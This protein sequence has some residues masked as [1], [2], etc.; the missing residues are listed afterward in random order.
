M[1]L[2]AEV[3]EID[4]ELGSWWEAFSLGSEDEREALMEAAKQ[5]D[6]KRRSHAPVKTRV[7]A[8][9]SA[10][11][12]GDGDGDGDEAAPSEN[13]GAGLGAEPVRKR[14]RRRRKPSEARAGGEPV[15]AAG[16]HSD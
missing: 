2:R 10:D 15:D 12:D 7:A 11:A 16:G 5:A 13:A 3:G 9:E 8:S 6:N 4:A 1:R 14:R